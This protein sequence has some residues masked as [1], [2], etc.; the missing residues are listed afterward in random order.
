MN[1]PPPKSHTLI[2]YDQPEPRQV[3]LTSTTYSMGRDTHNGIVIPHKSISRQHALLLRMPL[4]KKG[5]YGYRLL[6]GNSAGQPSLNGLIINGVK[7]AT[8]DLNPGDSIIL[9]GVIA[10]KYQIIDIPVDSK[11]LNYIKFNTP[12][13]TDLNVKIVNYQS[14]L[15]SD[16][17]SPDDYPSLEQ[18]LLCLQELDDVSLFSDLFSS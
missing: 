4:L 7:R 16:A 13:I 2:I 5:H 17:V 9:G 10:L 1:H 8:W 12:E 3:F 14:T 18:Q 15:M 11:Y 6:D